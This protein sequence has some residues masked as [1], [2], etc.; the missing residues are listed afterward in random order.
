V[1][2]FIAARVPQLRRYEVEH[3]QGVAV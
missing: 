3:S 2:G 1:T